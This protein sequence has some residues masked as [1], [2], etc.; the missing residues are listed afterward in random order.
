MHDSLH[1]SGEPTCRSL[2]LDDDV[3]YLLSHSLDSIDDLRNS[4]SDLHNSLS[5]LRNSLGRSRDS[6]R[7]FTTR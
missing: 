6:L 7:H 5:D 4:M 2:A 3:R 1:R